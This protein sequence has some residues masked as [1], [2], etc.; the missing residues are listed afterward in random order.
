MEQFL[1]DVRAYAAACGLEP[2]TVVQ[3][4]G[5][6]SGS[7]WGKWESGDGSPTLRTA[8]RIRAYMQANPPP[9]ATVAERDA[10]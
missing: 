8:D 3:R 5:G 9:V 1:A 7:S 10:A 4:A 2:G 6:V